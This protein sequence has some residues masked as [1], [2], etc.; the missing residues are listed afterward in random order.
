MKRAF[1]TI[2]DAA[3]AEYAKK[4]RA[5]LSKFHPDIPLIEFTDTEIDETKE[6]R[7][8]IFY[9]SAP[10][11]AKKLMDEGY[12]ELIK[13]DCD[14]I[15]T[16]P[17][18]VFG[19]PCEVGT[20]YNYNRMDF[21]KY[22]IVSVMDININFYY[23]NGFVLLKSKEF[24]E[25]WL[26]L[27]ERPNIVNFRFREQDLL[28]ILCHYGNYSVFPLEQGKIFYGLSG[29][30]YWAESVMKDGKIYVPSKN[31]FIHVIHFA[32]G[33]G[34]QKMNYRTYFSEEVSDYIAALIRA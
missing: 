16:G 30:D 14:Q 34:A 19:T 23:N 25:H 13:L 20:V 11:F 29:K 1:Y 9:K 6:R 8:D 2:Y 21:E 15:I 4:M 18:D 32:G 5:S 27:C 17:I 28:N 24:V 33:Q 10:Y 22:G 12:E 31:A 3:N 7:P 26:M